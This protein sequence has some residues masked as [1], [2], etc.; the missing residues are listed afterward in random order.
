MH[1][2]AVIYRVRIRAGKSCMACHWHVFHPHPRGKQ[3]CQKSESSPPTSSNLVRKSCFC[4][5]EKRPTIKA[6]MRYD[7]WL[8]CSQTSTLVPRCGRDSATT[9]LG[10]LIRCVPRVWIQTFVLFSK[11]IVE[12]QSSSLG[13]NTISTYIPSRW[14]FPNKL[15][16]S[17][18]PQ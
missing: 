15:S 7:R 14:P 8:E 10:V 11:T 13:C 17:I 16:K 2:I 18:Q 1:R 6:Q 3:C 4:G 5:P 9:D 12:N